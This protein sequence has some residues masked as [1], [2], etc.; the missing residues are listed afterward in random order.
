METE[1]TFQSLMDGDDY[2]YDYDDYYYSTEDYEI[3]QGEGGVM[4]GI[5]MVFHKKLSLRLFCR[6]RFKSF[7]NKWQLQWNSIFS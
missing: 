1:N 7:R 3:K 5:Q 6:R 2:Y 4:M